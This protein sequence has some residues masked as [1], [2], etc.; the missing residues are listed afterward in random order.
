MQADNIGRQ[1][2]VLDRRAALRVAELGWRGIGARLA[3][4]GNE[5][6]TSG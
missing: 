3:W 5:R 1:E 2:R 6:T 4:L